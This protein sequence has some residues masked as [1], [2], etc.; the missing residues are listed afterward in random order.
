MHTQDSDNITI[1][2]S[3]F[4]DGKQVIA[5]KVLSLTEIRNSNFHL[6]GHTTTRL[7]DQVC[8]P[9][10]LGPMRRLYRDDL[11]SRRVRD[12]TDTDPSSNYGGTSD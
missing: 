4:V 12:E 11:V 3:R 8:P 1:S 6:L 2:V 7:F 10:Y 9:V 5:T